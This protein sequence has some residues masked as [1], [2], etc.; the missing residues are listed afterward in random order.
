MKKILLSGIML[1]V[2]AAPVSAQAPANSY[3]G[4]FSNEARTEWCI[5]GTGMITM[6]LIV[7]PA[8]DGLKCLDMS[9]TENDPTAAVRFF[10]PVWHD[11]VKDAMLGSFP[12]NFLS[13]CLWYC[14]NDWITLAAVD[15]YIYRDTD[16][17][18]IEIGPNWNV[19]VPLPY[20]VYGNCE[21]PMV[22]NEAIPFTTFYINDECGPIAVEESSWGAIKNLYR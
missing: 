7:L 6:Y 12:D 21:D 22:E 8:A 4:L 19:P 9:T 16:P 5:S 17:V 13:L 11:D 18:S 3:I 10:T 20:P 14:H 1:M 15:G 2:L